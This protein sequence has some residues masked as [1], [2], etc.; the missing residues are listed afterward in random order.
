MSRAAISVADQWAR[1]HFFIARNGMSER[2][3]SIEKRARA[4]AERLAQDVGL[5]VVE[6]SWKGSGKKGAL[7]VYIDK[8]GG[9]GHDDCVFVSRQMSTSRPPC[10][11]ITCRTSSIA[12]SESPEGIP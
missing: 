7:R 4:I 6:V 1:A 12:S 8:P 3:H 2:S 9:I 11:S 5:E 10:F